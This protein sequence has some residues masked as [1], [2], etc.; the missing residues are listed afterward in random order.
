MHVRERSP[1]QDVADLTR[2]PPPDLSSHET[3]IAPGPV[4]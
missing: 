4:G 3:S 2:S 1:A